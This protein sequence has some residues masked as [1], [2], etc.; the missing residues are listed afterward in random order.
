MSELS[1]RNEVKTQP[2]SVG[3]LVNVPQHV[4]ITT[5]KLEYLSRYMMMREIAV[6]LISSFMLFP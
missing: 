2:F 3:H 5:F 4:L 6:V 1:T